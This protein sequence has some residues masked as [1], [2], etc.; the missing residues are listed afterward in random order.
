MERNSIY[1]EFD[2]SISVLA[3]NGYGYEEYKNQIKNKFDISKI[4]VIIFPNN[5]EKVAISFI[6]GMFRDI[7]SK[8]NKEEIEKYIEI[9]SSSKEL[10]EKI[11]NNIKF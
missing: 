4:N 7:L 9:K 2:K 1:L 11:I 6:Q 10:T 8:I 5:I 3:G